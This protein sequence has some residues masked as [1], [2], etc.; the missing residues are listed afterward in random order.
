MQCEDFPACG[1]SNQQECDD[2]NNNMCVEC[3]ERPIW[4]NAVCK[5]CAIERQRKWK[6]ED[7]EL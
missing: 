6:E 2:L 4:R 5:E 1:H 7:E 3:H